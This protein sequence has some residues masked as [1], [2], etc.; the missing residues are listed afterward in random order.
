MTPASVIPVE[1]ALSVIPTLSL[2][3]TTATV[4]LDTWATPATPTGTSAALVRRREM[5]ERT[6][7]VSLQASNIVLYPFS[8]CHQVPTRASMAVNVS[9]PLAPSCVTVAEVTLDHAVNKM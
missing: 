4:Q 5:S 7:R 9:T 6:Q 2:A 3:C 1:R 8:L